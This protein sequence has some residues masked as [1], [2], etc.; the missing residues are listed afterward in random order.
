MSTAST[1]GEILRITRRGIQMQ[2]QSCAPVRT[3]CHSAILTGLS[4]K[5][6]FSSGPLASVPRHGLVLP[7]HAGRRQPFSASPFA[8]PPS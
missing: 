5:S 6:A 3:F 4:R 2:R 7:C 8:V 1:I